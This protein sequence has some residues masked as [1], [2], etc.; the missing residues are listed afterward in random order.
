R[1]ARGTTTP[2]PPDMPPPS[3]PHKNPRP[4]QAFP[5]PQPRPGNPPRNPPPPRLPHL[6][7]PLDVRDEDEHLHDVVHGPSRGFHQVL[8]LGEDGLG[9]RVHAVAADGPLRP[10]RHHA[11]DV[12]LVAHHEAVRPRL[13]WRGRPAV[14]PDA[15]LHS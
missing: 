6:L 5:P 9:L 12:Y 4:A 14:R 15:L 8:D 11:G 10:A 3:S 1:E 2:P 13:G 7:P